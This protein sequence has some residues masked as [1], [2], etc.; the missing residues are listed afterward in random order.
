M[1]ARSITA[2]AL[3]IAAGLLVASVAGAI[4]MFVFVSQAR[5]Q[6]EGALRDVG[7][8][9]WVL[10]GA[11]NRDTG[12]RTLRING[13]NV[14]IHSGTTPD[15]LA[16]VLD[17]AAAKCGADDSDLFELTL[18]DRTDGDGFVGCF[19]AYGSLG[20]TDMVDLARAFAGSGDLSGFGAFHYTYAR[21]TPTGTH[22]LEAI[23]DAIDIAAMFPADTDA[24][25]T[26]TP[27]IPRPRDSRRILS[28][29]QAGSPYH[30]AVYADVPGELADM[31][32]SYTDALR[33]GGWDVYPGTNDERQARLFAFRDGVQSLVVIARS[34][35]RLTVTIA[36][37]L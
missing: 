25:G 36:T 22:V 2:V 24:P 9:M 13:A 3:K 18:Q 17:R 33:A 7:Q 16:D 14:A 31:R 11:E 37:G 35:D 4:L 12:A 8:G 27:G 20:A 32:A 26:D 6:L 21:V 1:T 15:A 19:P 30:I 5:A 28:A 10:D 23:V 29:V 34:D